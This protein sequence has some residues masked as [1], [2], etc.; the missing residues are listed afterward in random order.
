MERGAIPVSSTRLISSWKKEDRVNGSLATMVAPPWQK[1]RYFCLVI[2]DSHLILIEG[3]LFFFHFLYY[4]LSLIFLFF[5]QSVQPENPSVTIFTLS[6]IFS[7]SQLRWNIISHSFLLSECNLN[8]LRL[9]TVFCHRNWAFILFFCFVSPSN[10][11]TVTWKIERIKKAFVTRRQKL[12]RALCRI[13]KS[14]KE[15]KMF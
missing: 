7:S 14:E 6:C 12:E 11:S 1:T 3:S 9:G 13:L 10:L 15:K 8:I 4:P 5:F 2:S